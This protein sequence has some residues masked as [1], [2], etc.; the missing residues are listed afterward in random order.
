MVGE[1]GHG[2]VEVVE[3]MVV[4]AKEKETEGVGKDL[5]GGIEEDLRGGVMVKAVVTD[6]EEV[7]ERVVTGW[8]EEVEERVVAGLEVEVE[9]R[10]GEDWAE[11]VEE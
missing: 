6:L 9:E 8:E 4:A 5:V 11:G 3:I 1:G 2:F 10:V 7:E